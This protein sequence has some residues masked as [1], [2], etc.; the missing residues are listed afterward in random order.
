MCAGE[1]IKN[2]GDIER[3]RI[4]RS[5]PGALRKEERAAI[6]TRRDSAGL[7][8]P[9]WLGDEDKTGFHDDG[10]GLAI[11]GGGIRSA[12]F[13]LGILQAMAKEEIGE[14]RDPLRCKTCRKPRF[15]RRIDYLSTVSGGGYIG[16]FWGRFY[17]RGEQ[18]EREGLITARDDSHQVVAAVEEQ[19]SYQWSNPVYWLRENGRYL[20]PAGGGDA[21]FAAASWL[22]GWIVI[23]LLI[24]ALVMAAVLIG[25]SARVVIANWCGDADGGGMLTVVPID[26]ALRKAANVCASPAAMPPQCKV[27]LYT[28]PQCLYAWCCSLAGPGDS[29]LARYAAAVFG[30]LV[31][32][33]LGVYLALCVV[34][35]LVIYGLYWALRWSS[36]EYQHSV[37]SWAR[38]ST[39]DLCAAALGVLLL[40][41]A[42]RVID[43]AGLYIYSREAELWPLAGGGLSAG[44]G[45]LVRTYGLSWVFGGKPGASPSL[46]K[47]LPLLSVAAIVFLLLYGS[48][49]TAVVYA[50]VLEPAPSPPYIVNEC[51]LAAALC[52]AVVAGI[53]LGRPMGFLNHTSLSEFYSVRLSR[54]FLGATNTE[55]WKQ[56]GPAIDRPHAED[57]VSLAGYQPHACGGPLHL[58]NVTVNES[59]SGNSKI[60]QR[61]R[62]GLNMAVS[63]LGLS[64]GVSHHAVFETPGKGRSRPI[65]PVPECQP[66]YRVFAERWASPEEL[67]LGTWVGISG[68]AFSTGMGSYSSL[69]SSL[70]LGMLNV[71]LG[72]WWDSGRHPGCFLCPGHGNP[73]TKVGLVER[74]GRLFG[75][76]LRYVAP[77]QSYL[78]DEFLGQ[79]HGPSLQYWN[80]S[81][82]GH[83]E[84]TGAL[85]LIRR[86][87][88]L[89]IVLDNGADPGYAFG[90]LEVLVR[91]ARTDFQADIQF[92][93]SLDITKR[94][95]GDT[96]RDFG[97]LRKYWLKDTEYRTEEALW[98]A[99]KALLQGDEDGA[100]FG[101][102]EDLRPRDGGKHCGHHAALALI[103]Y[104]PL[105]RVG[106]MLWIKPSVSGD[107]DKDIIGY[108]SSHDTFPNETTLDQFFDEAQWESYRKLGRHIGKRLMRALKTEV[109]IGEGDG[110][111]IPVYQ[112]LLNRPNI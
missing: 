15:L 26:E 74:S 99:L 103:R 69:G 100:F 5:Y 97:A 73:E 4:E 106:V 82:G 62:K 67:R 89:I 102:L 112:A 92:I 33:C 29:E 1:S 96:N 110:G 79:F 59:A 36:V 35:F 108:Q 94:G 27:T 41:V 34:H 105:K 60:Q 14:C 31:P 16:S 71:R 54:A 85:E 91:R 56:D 57:D 38:R 58:I 95:S 64:V 49:L 44:L 40:A 83:Y 90:D 61:D 3:D 42:L 32:W 28:L 72:Y 50:A 111:K 76:L 104:Q 21:I 75:H 23:Q 19:I 93:D 46:G 70:F 47:L 80:L 55:R 98:A 45:Y 81:D 86:Q 24:A 20:T 37:K 51:Y 48:V 7:R 39:A 52:I 17:G 6:K 8:E 22:R 65:L 10:I 11:S 109:K 12:I 88:P 30:T 18:L 107:E 66:G 87:L 43:V 63:P 2:V 9:C 68:A 84:N 13:G 77:V 101:P 53:V 78:L 25:L